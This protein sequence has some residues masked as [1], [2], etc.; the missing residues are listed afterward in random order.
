MRDHKYD[1]DT[2][3][4]G[5]SLRAVLYAHNGGYPLLLNSKFKPLRFDRID[6]MEISD[7]GLKTTSAE[8]AWS[9]ILLK[10]ALDGLVPF[11]SAIDS[12]RFEGREMTISLGTIA[13]LKARFRECIV[14]EDDNL[15]LENEADEE[16]EQTLRVIDWFSVK[17]GMK[18]G[19]D[20]IEDSDDFVNKV[21]FYVS[22]RIDGNKELK[23]CA[24]ESYMTIEQ[25]QDFDYSATM[26]RFKTEKLMKD[27]GI[28]GAKRGRSPS[29]KQQH[30][31]IKLHPARRE[32]RQH[33]R[34]RYKDS[35]CV[36]FL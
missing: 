4:V 22:E 16:S 18:H 15:V 7:I 30:F 28:S 23:D 32:K 35:S 27:S 1:F 20:L 8:E 29:G 13:V 19:L 31:P 9:R 14:F 10:H 5:H 21:H 3:V 26:A 36:K 2:V 34:K 33:L 24:S 6:E 17:S 12:V 25:F 11:G